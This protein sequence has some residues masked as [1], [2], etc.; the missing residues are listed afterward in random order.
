MRTLHFSLL[1]LLAAIVISG[2]GTARAELRIDADYPGGNILVESIDGDVVA[3]RQDLRDTEG[4]WFYWSFR[5]YGAEGKTLTFRFTNRN[6]LGTRGPAVSLDAGRTW[7]WLGAENVENTSFSYTFLADVPCVQFAF[8]PSYQESDL[9]RFL[10]Q[11]EANEHLVVDELC[12][13]RKGRSVER[14]HVGRVDGNPAHRILLTCRHHSCESTASFVL[15][16]ML[17]AV[18]A[19]TDDGKW[20]RENVE[21]LAVPLVDKDGVEQGDQG[22]NRRP[23]DHNRDYDGSSLYRSVA[24]LRSFVP[25]WSDGRLSVAIDLH[26]PYIRGNHNEAIYL[27]GNRDPKIWNEQCALSKILESVCRG[28]LPYKAADNLP[29]GQSWNTE[30]NYRAGKS[31]SRWAGELKGMRLA[32]S[33]EIPYA[34]VGETTVTPDLARSFGTRLVEALRRYLDQP[35]P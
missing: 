1:P 12:R 17:A 22:K 11:H 15:E 21:V 2:P 30:N 32:T 31:C 26:C 24:A 34:N 16:G 4:W 19:D 3:L 23:R 35:P 33:F 10:K 6:V 28:S 18:L 14:L 25:Q 7:S 9:R 5:A 20:F 29:F 8:A 27:V 13:T